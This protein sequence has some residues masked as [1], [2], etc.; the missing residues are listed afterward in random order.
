MQ[1]GFCIVPC[2]K[3]KIWKK[4]PEKGA[5]QAKE[6]YIGSFVTRC[7]AYAELFFP[8]RY[9]ILS[10]KYGFLFPEDWVNENYDV[11]FTRKNT[12]PIAIETLRQQA[13]QKNLFNYAPIVVVSGKTYGEVAQKVWGAAPIIMPLQNF[14]TY[15]LMMRQLKTAIETRIPFH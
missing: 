8:D 4:F 12:F 5:T 11:T 15:G 14:K 1:N 2:G 6:V 10:A 13:A 3:E 9:C 7:R